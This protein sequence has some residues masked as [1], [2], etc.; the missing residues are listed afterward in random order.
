MILNMLLNFGF[1][2]KFQKEFNLFLLLIKN[3]KIFNIYNHLDKPNLFIL[4]KKFQIQN[5][6]KQLMKLMIFK[7]NYF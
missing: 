4:K 2:I 1:Q 3:L 6:F 7:K 5:V